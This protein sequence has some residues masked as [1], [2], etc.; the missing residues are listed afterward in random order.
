MSTDN[1]HIA[2]FNISRLKAP[3]DSPSMKEFV[4]FLAPVNKF[5]EESPGFVW[6]L[7]AP[8]GQ[9]SSYLPPAYEDPMIVTNLTVWKDIESL[10]NFVYQ[11][12]HTYFLRG[13][14]KWFDQVADY[15]TVLWW[16]PAGHIPSIEEAK[17]KLILLAKQ[18]PTSAA[19]TFQIQ[20]DASGK[21]LKSEAN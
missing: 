9:A 4:D 8:D 5:G 14:K 12:V 19:F 6:R 2:E 7:A 13:R 17:E 18:G 11:T 20:F 21:P 15:Q 1:F 10:K 3:L 16:V